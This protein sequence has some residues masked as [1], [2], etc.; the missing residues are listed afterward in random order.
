[1]AGDAVD[2]QSLE[3]NLPNSPV[4]GSTALLDATMMALEI[5]EAKTGYDTKMLVILTDGEE[6]AS[7]QYRG[8]QEFVRERLDDAQAD[9]AAIMFLA[10]SPDAWGNDNVFQNM[11]VNVAGTGD[12]VLGAMTYLNN[13]STALRSGLI[14]NTSYS[15]STTE[16]R[17]VIDDDGAVNR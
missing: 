13:Q 12:S 2:I 16:S 11:T 9:G 17:T 8:R 5:L 1:M 4:G 7:V 14:S 3:L 10:V 6:N 15:G